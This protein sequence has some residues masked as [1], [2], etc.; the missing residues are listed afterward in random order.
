MRN[1][2]AAVRATKDGS[3]RFLCEIF[4]ELP[5]AEEYPDYFELISNPI[6][7]ETIEENITKKCVRERAS[8][9]VDID[10]PSANL[11]PVLSF[12]HASSA[13]SRPR[14]VLRPLAF[15]G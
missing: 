15:A 11:L 8:T 7:L 9:T 1:A 3:G 10:R 6:D 4:E 2:L 13:C 5:S 14:P 12:A